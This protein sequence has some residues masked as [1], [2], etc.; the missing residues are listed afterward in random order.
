MSPKIKSNKNLFFLLI[1]ASC[2]STVSNIF[3]TASSNDQ[4]LNM[5]LNNAAKYRMYAKCFEKETTL[6]Y[7]IENLPIKEKRGGV[8]I[9][10]SR[11]A[12]VNV[13]NEDG[14]TALMWAAKTRAES[15]AEILIKKGADINAKDK[16][17]NTALMISLNDGY[18]SLKIIRL[19]VEGGNIDLKNNSHQTALMW[20]AKS[21]EKNFL[22][23]V[24]VGTESL[25]EALKMIIEV[26]AS[27][28]GIK[29]NTILSWINKGVVMTRDQI[30]QLG[31]TKEEVEEK[32]IIIYEQKCREINKLVSFWARKN[33]SQHMSIDLI[34][35]TIAYVLYSHKNLYKLLINT[36]ANV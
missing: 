21:L 25:K 26:D 33:I 22:I 31:A 34:Q 28:L 13:S 32:E 35:T 19:L 36:L 29:K 9:L 12:E 18:V 17:G 11:G 8:R 6:I 20:V 24:G 23:R 3:A 1:A 7:A 30:L 27:L 15:I 16:D 4:E 2:F 10:I 5:Y 14:R